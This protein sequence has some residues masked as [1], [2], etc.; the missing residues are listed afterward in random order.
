MGLAVEVSLTLEP[1]FR[2]RIVLSL[3]K[4]EN[5]MTV[6]TTM[7]NCDTLTSIVTTEN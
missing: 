1:S 5:L 3:S 2:T 4:M 6:L 7:R